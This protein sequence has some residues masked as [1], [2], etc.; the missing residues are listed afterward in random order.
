MPTKSTKSTPKK[1]AA[2]RKKAP[3]KTA[4]EKA[5]QAIAEGID[6]IEAEW[7]SLMNAQKNATSKPYS[8][9]GVYVIGDK[10]K[11]TQFGE[12]LVGRL[13]FPNKM[14][15]LFQAGHKILINGGMPPA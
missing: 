11:H 14:E 15:V 4:E 10:V 8:A 7:R 13:I 1:A 12:G 5:Q 6:A 9:K 3:K 2:P